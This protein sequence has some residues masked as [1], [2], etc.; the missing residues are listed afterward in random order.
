MKNFAAELI[1]KVAELDEELTMKYLEGE[2]ITIAEIK[3]A[4]R[5][6]VCE[7]KIFPVICGSSYRNKGVQLMLDAVVDYLP[8][9]IDVPDIKGTL[10]DG[11]EDGSQIC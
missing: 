11:T 6:G 9:P 5:K 4:L 10:E 2:E 1:E 7:V 3:A 8:A